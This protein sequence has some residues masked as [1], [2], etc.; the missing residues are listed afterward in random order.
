VVRAY[1]TIRAELAGYGHGMED[2]PEIVVLNKS[3]AV[4]KPMLARKRAALEKASG[5]KV[6]V[7]S[8][9]SGDGV[10][11]VLGALARAVENSRGKTRPVAA[12]RSWAP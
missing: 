8:G 7:M 12:T 4:T 1:R 3:D 2:K 10:D 6:F 5:Q 9:V 11:D